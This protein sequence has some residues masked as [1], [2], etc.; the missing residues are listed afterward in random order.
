MITNLQI[1][2]YVN[3][4]LNLNT[5][6][7][8]EFYAVL[9]ENKHPVVRR[10]VAKFLSQIVMLKQPQKILELGTNV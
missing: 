7:T 9:V 5:D 6:E 3:S 1:T 4:L 10:D 2:D 8:D